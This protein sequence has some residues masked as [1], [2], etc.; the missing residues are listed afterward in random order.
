MIT[1]TVG[2]AS[3]GKSQLEAG[4]GRDVRLEAPWQFSNH[5]RAIWGAAPACPGS[6]WPSPGPLPARE[7]I[8]RSVRRRI[9]RAIIAV[10]SPNMTQSATE[11]WTICT[12]PSLG[13]SGRLCRTADSAQG[14]PGKGEIAD[15]R[16]RQ[17]SGFVV[18][19]HQNKQEIERR[20]KEKQA[21]GG[22]V[23][24]PE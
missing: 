13:G 17:I 12:T 8:A 24:T 7:G 18:E 11:W 19:E 21:D 9:A 10:S 5:G 3:P 6:W 16:P 20:G 1:T 23:L 15:Q 2:C 4:L 22:L 14:V